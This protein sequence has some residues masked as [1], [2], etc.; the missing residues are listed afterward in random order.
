VDYWDN[1]FVRRSRWHA[2][3]ASIARVFEHEETFPTCETLSRVAESRARSAPAPRFELQE[4]KRRRRAETDVSARYDGQVALR[5]AVP[6]RHASW[7]DFYNAL[8]FIELSRAKRALHARQFAAMRTGTAQAGRRTREQDHLTILDE[9]SLL[10]AC[11]P[12]EGPA[13]EAAL[14]ARGTDALEGAPC[15]PVVFGHA[16]F[17]H[18]HFGRPPV[19]AMTVVL[20]LDVAPGARALDD[21]LDDVD[22]A[23]E[24]RLLTTGTFLDPSSAFSVLLREDG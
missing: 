8:V 23:L 24:A 14:R 13:Y 11:P 10:V 9:G 22:R 4:K 2:S 16:L 20:E 19:R 5:G 3:L 1:A 18:F 6:T 12:G 17:E 15:R 21:L 7:H